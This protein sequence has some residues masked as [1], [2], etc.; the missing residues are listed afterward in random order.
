MWGPLRAELKGLRAWPPLNLPTT[1]VARAILRSVGR[2]SEFL[3]KHLPRVGVVRDRLPNGHT[4]TLWSRGDDWIA[5]QVFWRGWEGYERETS[6]LFFRLAARSRVT[7]DVGAYVGFYA[8]LAAH[9]NPQAAVFAFEPLPSV[10]SRLRNN[11]EANGLSNIECVEAAV[12][13]ADGMADFYHVAAET[14]SSSSLSYDFMRPTAGLTRSRVRVVALDTFLG[15]RNVADVGLMK[16]DTET[17][18]IDVLRGATQLLRRSKPL[19]LCGVLPG[20]DVE[21]PLED[22]LRPLGCHFYLLGPRGPEA[23]EP[24]AADASRLNYL[25]APLEASEG[26]APVTTRAHSR[27]VVRMS[28]DPDGTWGLKDDDK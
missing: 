9:A 22:L 12:G 2:Q 13:A 3:I 1:A 5:N 6:A 26:L 25:F 19:I 23:R 11:V 20:H 21:G 7:L 8:L 17:T 24:V 18:E 14:P 4:L 27:R 10:F 15:E 28:G 16:I